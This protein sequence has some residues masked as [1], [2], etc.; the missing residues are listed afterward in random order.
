MRMRHQNAFLDNLE[1]LRNSLREIGAVSESSQLFAPAFEIPPA[2]PALA[3]FFDVAATGVTEL[4]SY[5]GTPVAL[6]D[7]MRNPRTRTT[8]TFASLVIVARAAQYIQL[9]GEPITI[10]TPTSANKGTALRDAVLRAYE[11]ELVR[12]DQLNIATLVPASSQPKLWASPLSEDQE[13][14]RANPLAVLPVDAPP[15][16]VKTIVQEVVATRTRDFHAATG[17]RLWHTLNLDN[18]RA[19]DAIRAR[20]EHTLH[21]SAG[22]RVH[23]HAVSSAFG[24]LGYDFGRGLLARQGEPP[25]GEAPAFLLVQHLARPDMVLHLYHRD[26]AY[27]RIPAYRGDPD[28]LYRQENDPHFPLVTSEPRE[29]LDSTFYTAQPPTSIEMDSIIAAQG[30]AGIVVSRYECLERYRDIAS[31]L[32]NAGV[33]LPGNPEHL[34]EWSLVMAMTGMMAA[35]DRGVLPPCD[36]ILVHGSGCYAS[37][38]YTPVPGKYLLPVSDADNLWKAV[39]QAAESA[40]QT[41]PGRPRRQFAAAPM[42]MDARR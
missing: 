25:L 34:R 27:S 20:V 2:G 12:P 42:A 4:G 41:S 21:P 31:F 32:S 35:A 17:R 1:F 28:G 3:A 38:S 7:L 37:D 16:Q 19:A 23:V 18:Y 11:H 30:G 10:V 22:K 5:A 26:F 40:S 14:R 39:M 33:S 9:T 8:K 6:L 24:L 13:L 15:G 29:V 36:D